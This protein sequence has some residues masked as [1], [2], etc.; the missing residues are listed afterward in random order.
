VDAVLAVLVK[1]KLALLAIYILIGF[2]CLLVAAF[3]VMTAA[4][5]SNG[6]L[7]DNPVPEQYRALV[8]QA[9]TICDDISA[10]LLAAQIDVESRWD[11]DAVG[12]PLEPDNWERKDMP[13]VRVVH[14]SGLAQF[15]PSA[16]AQ[17]GEDADRSGTSSPLE[18]ADAIDAQARFMCDNARQ[19]KEGIEAGTLRGSVTDLALA[20]YHAGWSTVQDAG[21][22]PRFPETTGYVARVN[23]LVPKYEIVV[24]PV[25]AGPFGQRVVQIARK[26]IGK[27]YVF[28]AGGT[29]EGYAAFDCSGLTMYAIYRASGGKIVLPHSSTE[30]L[31]LGTVVPRG[32][33]APGDLVFF[34]DPS[35]EPGRYHHVGIYIGGGKMIHAPQT[36]EFVKV[37]SA[38]VGWEG[39]EIVVARYGP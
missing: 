31:P 5:P 11:R 36:G 21:G 23:R 19:A 4:A 7:N 30:Q 28:A 37:G 35:H 24:D 10:P 39:E 25:I 6:V 20:G 13:G 18:P 26:Q 32:S 22:V 14:A 27:P 34:R 17:W 3:I 8:E 33:A 29:G 15:R 16:W 38:F 12:P 1:V 9:G 2:S